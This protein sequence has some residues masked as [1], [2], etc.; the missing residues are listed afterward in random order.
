MPL[1]LWRYRK[2]FIQ[3]DPSLF[4]K[5]II[6]SNNPSI[7]I[8]DEA[9]SNLDAAVESDIREAI[10]DK[11]RDMRLERAQETYK[12]EL[13]EYRRKFPVHKVTPATYAE[14]RAIREK[15]G[16]EYAKK[17]GIELE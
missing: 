9:T 4:I 7:L 15:V 14:E 6:K 1:K 13:E 8:F 3:C 5:S 2:N 17:F 16:K 12:K 11:I 10:R